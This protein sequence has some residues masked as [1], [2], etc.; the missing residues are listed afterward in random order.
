M[1]NNKGSPENAVQFGIKAASVLVAGIR[2]SQ[3]DSRVALNTE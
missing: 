3:L 2:A 1:E